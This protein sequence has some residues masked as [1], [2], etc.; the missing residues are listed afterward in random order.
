[1]YYAAV[2]APGRADDRVI[3]VHDNMAG[4]GG[5]T[6]TCGKR[7]GLGDLKVGVDLHA[8]LVG[9]AGHGVPV[10]ARLQSGHAHGKLAGFQHAG[11]DKLVD[12]ALVAGFQGA[13]GRLAASARVIS[14]VS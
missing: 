2:D 14:L 11:V 4:L 5:L 6:G 13:S 7:P 8:A 12:G 10:A 3:V 1:M 9:V